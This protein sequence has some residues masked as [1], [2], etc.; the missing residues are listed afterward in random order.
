MDHYQ[1][2]F[3]GNANVSFSGLNASELI[4]KLDEKG[5]CVSSGSACSSGNTSPS[6]VLTAINTPDEYINSAIRT[7]FSDFNTYEEIDYFI[8][9]LKSLI[10]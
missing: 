8:N 9:I 2:D 4:F 10:I 3:H 6:H 1:I 5:I 7:T